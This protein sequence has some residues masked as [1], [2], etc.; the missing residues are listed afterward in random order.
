MRPPIGVRA[1]RG[2]TLIELL[3]VIS[4]IA[5]LIALLLPAVQAAREAARRSQCIN[6][7]KQIGLALH[8][9]ESSNGSFPPAKLYSAGTTTFAND[10]GG[11]GLVLNTTMFTMILNGLEQSAKYN[12]YNFSLPSCNSVNAG[13]NMAVLG[14]PAAYLANTTVTTTTISTYF[15]PSDIVPSPY[16]NAPATPSAY[17]GNN[18]VRCSYLVCAS[19]YYET[20][21]PKTIATRPV[22]E[23]VFSGSDWS[24][25]I[26]SIKDGTSNT[27]VVGESRLQKTAVQYGGW[28]GQGLWTSTHALVYSTLN[29]NPIAYT[30]TMPNA[31][32]LL[33]QVA[34]ASNPQ[35]L[36]YAW[37][38]SSQHP[39]GVN[40]L[41]ADGSIHFIKSSVNPRT[42]FGLMTMRAGEVLSSD[43]Y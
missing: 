13:A 17:P 28:W 35:R 40:M 34:A 24:N 38:L 25:T 12:A 23:A 20:Y 6:N 30:G 26:A 43:S 5:V 2:F 1:G 42:W 15:C 21:N 29:S 36:G 32:A 19:Q 14:G 8:N 7:M 27:C 4:I 33:T 16:T 37:T 9:Y 18:A 10:P 22:D 11:S 41:F 3:V 31:P 39:G